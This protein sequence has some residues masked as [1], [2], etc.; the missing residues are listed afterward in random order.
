VLH[1]DQI[2]IHDNFFE[3]GGHSL[4]ATQVISRIRSAFGTE[5]PLRALFEAPTIAGLASR[6]APVGPR[7]DVVE[8]RS[9]DATPA[10]GSIVALHASGAKTPFFCVHGIGGEAQAFAALAREMDPE[11]PFHGIRLPSTIVANHFPS[12]E[13]LAA[14]YVAELRRTVPDGPYMLGG[15]SSGASIAYEMAQQLTAAGDEVAMVALLD[16]GLPN[17]R[18]AIAGGP[19]PI[20]EWVQNL[21]WWLVDDFKHARR[22]DLV[23]RL[24]SKATLLAVK[25]AT[26][27]G[28]GWLPHRQPDIRDRLGIPFF[29][30]EW[31]GF[32][33]DHVK[34]LM[35]YVPRAYP[36]RVTLFRARTQPLFRLHERDLGWGRMA[37]G[38]VDVH[39]IPGSHESIL[40]MPHVA[41][42]GKRMKEVLDAAEK[43]VSR[44]PRVA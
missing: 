16:S 39:I 29:S 17:N 34:S 8:P 12:I 33:E 32:L 23:L 43:R 27:R 14:V 41:A 1:R 30:E 5:L 38:G 21:L 6:L 4:L 35:A 26:F 24:R 18:R 40:G 25:L 37:R 22:A 44:L 11:R 13:S 9:G 20:A 3:L 42:L 2:G 36:G 15:Y 7:E 10:T 19:R 28:L 31:V